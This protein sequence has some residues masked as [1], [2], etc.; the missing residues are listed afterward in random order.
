MPGGGDRPELGTPKTKAEAGEAAPP[1]PTK[2]GAP[3]TKAEAGEAAPPPPTKPEAE[4]QNPPCEHLSLGPA[5]THQAG[6]HPRQGGP[7]THGEPEQMD[8]G[9]TSTAGTKVPTLAQTPTAG[10]T[11]C[12]STTPPTC[13]PTFHCTEEE[14]S[15]SSTSHSAAHSRRGNTL[16]A[17]RERFNTS[18]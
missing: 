1:P 5:P 13:T 9:E 16:L 14:P 2:Q 11:P 7:P 17:I 10:S 8:A 3:K 18:R 6:Q 4:S 15:E 12:T